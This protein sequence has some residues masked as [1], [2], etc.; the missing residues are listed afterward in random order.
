MCPFS[1]PFFHL[2]NRANRPAKG[3][4]IGKE[5]KRGGEKGKKRKGCSW[6]SGRF[7]KLSAALF[8]GESRLG[9]GGGGGEGFG[10]WG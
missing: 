10:G 9:G 7:L 4:K 1:P 3:K 5:G 8:A 2:N 6:S